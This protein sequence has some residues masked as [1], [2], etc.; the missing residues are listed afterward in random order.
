MQTGT[1]TVTQTGTKT[2]MQTVTQTHTV[3][4][5]TD[6]GHPLSANRRYAPLMGAPGGGEKAGK[7]WKSLERYTK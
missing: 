4:Q 6:K 1:Q 5:A 7:A 3:S 2:L